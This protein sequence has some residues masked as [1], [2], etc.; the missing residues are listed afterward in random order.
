[1][2]ARGA[3]CC[4]ILDG[5]GSLVRRSLSRSSPRHGT[6]PIHRHLCYL[7]R[8]KSSHADLKGINMFGKG[9]RL[10]SLFGFEI[11][12]DW[13][14]FFIALLLTWS[15]ALGVFPSFVRGLSIS[16]YWLMGI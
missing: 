8:E 15:L 4:P 5:R 9:V 1:M 12:I 11:R 14:W 7:Q 3:G 2:R 6:R 16:S 13:S 10:F